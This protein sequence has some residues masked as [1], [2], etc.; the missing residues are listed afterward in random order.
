MNRRFLNK[1]NFIAVFLLLAAALT[2]CSAA[3]GSNRAKENSASG[4]TGESPE[5]ITFDWYIN[6]SWYNTPWGQNAVSQAITDKTGVSI[7]FITPQGN[8]A[9]KLNAL[10]ASKT[11]PD[12]ITIGWWEPQL[13]EMIQGD[14][15]YALNELADE[16]D[17]YFWEVTD[18][19]AVS[20]YTQPDGNIYCYP[21]S[22]VSPNDVETNSEISSNQTFL[23]R[24][25]IYE[26]IGSPDMTTIEGFEGAVR[27]AA[28]MFPEVD[29][30]PL[31]PIGGH[32]F[33][34]TGSVSFDQY[35]Q[36]F[37]AV[38][39]EK[40]GKLYDRDTDPEYIEWLKMFRRLGEDGLLAT[41]IFI[42]QRIQMEEKIAEGRYFCMLYQHTDM[43]SQQKTLYAK[44]PD[45]IYIAVDGPKNRNG[46]DHVLP[47][48]SVSGWT[49]TLVSKNCKYPDRA[50]KFIDFMISE[51][52]QK[53]VYLGVEGVTYDVIDG[54][55][56]VKPEVIELLNTDRTTYDELYGADDAYWMFQDNVMQLQWR[57]GNSGPTA[58]LEEW[59]Y[60][61]VQ[62]T[63]QYDVILPA[64]T[65]DAYISD[66]IDNLWSETLQSL[67]LAE[68]DEEF[69]RILEEYKVKRAELGYDQ[70]QEKRY[71]YVRE[72]KK[73]L[74][75]D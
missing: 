61:Y 73:K 5:Q 47:T 52:G 51:E 49:V 65:E 46:D 20:W 19:Q 66:R 70:L 42:D 33:D 24:K 36:N 75:L 15:V 13:N 64:D 17:A 18:P 44:N 74:G 55:E 7:N 71:Q 28:Q 14:M 57:Q 72:A 34:D 41:D 67:L 8:E 29:G 50:I 37:L 59:T 9:E 12:L 27:K 68:S 22:S 31:I 43:A 30:K 23:V 11:L 62:F 25:D 54:K 6:Y 48:S 60:K 45:S 1:R 32:I 63:G 21:C 39:Y 3:L 58:Q 26:A 40:D 38:P 4:Q 35:V 16:Y 2:G 56:V 69:D 10:I 53:L